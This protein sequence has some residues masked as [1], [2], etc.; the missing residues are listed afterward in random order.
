MKKIKPLNYQKLIYKKIIVKDVIDKLMAKIKPLNYQKLIYKKI[1]V[2]DVIDKLNEIVK[3]V[4]RLQNIKIKTKPIIIN[5]SCPKCKSK[6]TIKR[7]KRYNL[8]R[9]YTQKY[10]CKNCNYKFTPKNM[11]YRMRVS[12]TKIKKAIELFNQG[13]SYSQIAKKIKGVSRQTVGRWLNKYKVPKKDRV[14]E[15]EIK[16][17]YGTYTRKFNIKYK[18]NKN[19]NKN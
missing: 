7:G 1:I 6:N 2:K 18:K 3:E 17:Q 5:P 16:N 10:G 4:N 13:Y 14:F 11:E 19:I 9:G 12:E 8:E 15:R